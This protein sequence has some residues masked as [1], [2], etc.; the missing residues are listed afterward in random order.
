MWKKRRKKIEKKEKRE[1]L[2]IILWWVRVGRIPK[3]KW[4]LIEVEETFFD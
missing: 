4:T 1:F 3:K 2:K